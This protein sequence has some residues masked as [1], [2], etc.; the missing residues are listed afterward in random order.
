MNTE[1]RALYSGAIIHERYHIQRVIGAGGFGITYEAWDSK[2]NETVALKEY[3]PVDIAQRR[4]GVTKVSAIPGQEEQYEKFRTKFLEEARVIY[5]YQNHPNIVQ[6]KHLFYENNTAYYAME[7]LEGNDL[8]AYIKQ[9]PLTWEELE[10]VIEQ[11]VRALETLHKTEII[12]CD[13]SPDNIFILQNGQVKV[14]D[15]GAAKH[16]MKGQSSVIILKKGYAP[17]EQFASNGKLGVWTDIYALAVT[18]YYAYTGK[19]PPIATERFMSDSTV[20]PSQMG[21]DIPSQKWENALKKGMALR[22][23]DRYQNINEFWGELKQTQTVVT[24]HSSGIQAYQTEKSFYRLEGI[25]G[26]FR[27]RSIEI[28]GSRYLGTDATKCWI[29]YPQGSPG[30]SRVHMRF[31]VMEGQLCAMDANSTY[32]TYL[33]G[34]RM[35]PGLVYTLGEGMII[36]FGECEALQVVRNGK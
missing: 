33:N 14:I 32:G 23:E 30:I 7:Y 11:T 5:Q 26:G 20:W 9:G 1:I 24:T 21:M 19:M 27:G 13:I 4:K 16:I 15:L 10:G 6:V 18:I 25:R 35:T 28:T 17:P 12:H 8:S 2:T 34:R 36:E 29:V 31:L 22:I 3:M